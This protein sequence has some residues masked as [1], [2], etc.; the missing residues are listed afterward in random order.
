MFPTAGMNIDEADCGP[1]LECMTGALDD[2]VL[3]MLLM[4]TQRSNMELCI[5]FAVKKSFLILLT[6]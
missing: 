4:S 6:F 3:Q 2:E 1:L 5:T